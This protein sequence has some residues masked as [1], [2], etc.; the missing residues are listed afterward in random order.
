MR[1]KEYMI[2]LHYIK[3]GSAKRYTSNTWLVITFHSQNM[4][5]TTLEVVLSH[6][7]SVADVYIL[8]TIQTPLAIHEDLQLPFRR[9]QNTHTIAWAN[10]GSDSGA[11][12]DPT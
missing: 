8:W 9:Y 3:T 5:P 2:V 6:F 10:F 7:S 4:D 1:I 12:Q 11:L